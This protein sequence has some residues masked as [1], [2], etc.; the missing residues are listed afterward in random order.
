MRIKQFFDSLWEVY[1]QMAPSSLGIRSLLEER[2][3]IWMNDHVAFRTFDR[4]P[5]ALKDLE[6]HLLAL[7][8]KRFEPYQF[9]AKKLQAFG[10]LHPEE[11]HPRVFLSE[12]ET[13][14]LSSKANALIDDLVAQIEPKRT[15]S[16][17]CLFAGP[18]W[19]IPS[20]ET[21]LTLLE[22][23]EYAA[24]VAVNGLCANHFTVSV[25]MLSELSELDALMSFLE[26][27]GFEMN[28]AGGRIKGSPEVKLMQGST[29]A[30]KSSVAPPLGGA[31]EIT[32]CYVEFAQRFDGFQGFVPK[33]A[34]KIFESTNLK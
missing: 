7:G 20:R 8:Y 34:D 6:P 4:S 28:L 17:D 30:D 29:I 1:T 13:H 2:G 33:S 25:N 11:G 24:W 23:S 22:E 9:E 10:Y 26:E 12:L 27:S 14:K 18:L 16:P 32:T 31:Y 15:K 3:E 5:M 21:Y 19:E